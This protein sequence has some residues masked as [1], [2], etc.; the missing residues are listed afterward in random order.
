L[1]KKERNYPAAIKYVTNY[2]TLKNEAD[3]RKASDKLQKLMVDYEMREKDYTITLQKQEIKNKSYTIAGITVALGLIV[4]IIVL[5]ALNKRIR[6]TAIQSIYKQN[7][8]AQQRQKLIDH[9]LKE[10]TNLPVN[11]VDNQLMTNLLRLLDD[12]QIFRNQDLS[13]ESI[14]GQLSTNTTYV[15]QLINKQF[16]CNFNVL[17]NRYRID[18][19]KNQISETK[20]HNLLMKQVVFDAGFSSRS[21]FY[22]AFKNEVG[23]TPT[24][25]KKVCDLENK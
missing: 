4:T 12:E 9:L 15:S 25:F 3:K 20:R 2:L 18:F 5:I 24:Q 6:E 19:C 7:L 21:T 8:E 11:Q 10:Q 13:L 14:A 16:G 22:S 17:I 23:I 1:Y